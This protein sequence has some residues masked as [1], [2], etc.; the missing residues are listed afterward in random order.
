M[1]QDTGAIAP[2]NRVTLLFLGR[3]ADLAG[4]G[5]RV[6]AAPLDWTSLLDALGG[7]LAEVVQ[8]AKVR[9]ALNGLIVA[10]KTALTA[11]AGDEVA[12]LP[13]VSGG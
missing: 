10:D 13:P 7:E 6:C 2:A 12:L 4:S 9:V 1:G 3:L 11:A 8:D 5:E